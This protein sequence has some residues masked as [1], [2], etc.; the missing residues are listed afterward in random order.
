M[1]NAFNE[2]YE[3]DSREKTQPNKVKRNH[4][5]IRVHCLSYYMYGVNNPYNTD[6]SNSMFWLTSSSLCPTVV[7]KIQL[8]PPKLNNYS[9][10]PISIFTQILTKSVNRFLILCTIKG[11]PKNQHKKWA[12]AW[13][14]LSSGFPTKWGSN[15][16]PLL[17]RLTSQ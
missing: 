11:T 16:S 2:Y 13:R 6:Q 1:E 9:I 4:Y 17:Q 5:Q 12:L 3:K 8:R 10:Y 7:F 14:N 15:Q